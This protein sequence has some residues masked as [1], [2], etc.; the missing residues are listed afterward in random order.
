MTTAKELSAQITKAMEAVTPGPWAYQRP[1]TCV[2]GH[3]GTANVRVVAQMDESRRGLTNWQADL[4]YIAAVQPNNMRV[5]LSALADAERDRDY[6][7]DR[8][9]R[10]A[11][12]LG[13]ETVQQIIARA[14]AAEQELTDTQTANQCMIE[15]SIALRDR[16]D[17]RIA[18]LEQQIANIKAS[19]DCQVTIA[20]GE[21][22]RARKAEAERATYEEILRV[23]CGHL[24]LPQSESGPADDLSLYDRALEQADVMYRQTEAERVE[25]KNARYSAEALLQQMTE[26]ALEVTRALTGLSGGG[27]EMFS[28][29]VGNIYKADIEKCCGVVHD[30]HAKINGLLVNAVKSKNAAEVKLAEAV[31]VIEPLAKLAS[32][33]DGVPLPKYFGDIDFEMRYSGKDKATVTVD[34]LRAA[35]SFL[36]KLEAYSK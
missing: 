20:A 22:E 15:D 2:K 14:E 18:E 13:D 12:F 24:E 30:R 26:Y 4:G 27:S 5:I 10:L 6:S 29:R 32:D 17:S 1:D 31:K 25:H 23:V 7:H 11:G 33:Y 28:G 21:E 3:M 16:A 8:A 36:S 34:K 19:R 35:R 9:M